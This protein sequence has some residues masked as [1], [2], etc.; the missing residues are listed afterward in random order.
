[1]NRCRTLLALALCLSLATPIFAQSNQLPKPAGPTVAPPATVPYIPVAPAPYTPVV[2]APPQLQPGYFPQRVTA[3][4]PPQPPGSFAPAQSS[5]PAKIELNDGTTLTGAIHSDSPL[6]CIAIFGQT[7]IP[8]NQIKGIEWRSVTDP[9]DE[10]ARKATL[11]LINGDALTVSVAIPSIQVKTSWGHAT[12]ELSQVQSILMTIEKVKWTD[13]PDG[14]RALVP[15]GDGPD[16][17]QPK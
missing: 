13:T 10:Q 14:R 4:I 8:F 1:M 9:D 16:E 12:V 11:V 3:I 15:A 6:Q 2:P 7:V 17:T 5:V